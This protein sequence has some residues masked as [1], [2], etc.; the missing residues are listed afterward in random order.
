MAEEIKKYDMTLPATEIDAALLAAKNAVSY[1]PQTPTPEQQAQA[2]ANMGLREITL[3]TLLPV[4][5]STALSDEEN[6]MLNAAAAENRPLC[7]H[8]SVAAEEETISFSVFANKLYLPTVTIYSSRI[9]YTGNV[10]IFE[11]IS[12][13]GTT[14]SAAFQ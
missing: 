8:F 11:A 4:S 10:A 6:A 3:T 14:W 5:E 7:I 13:D 1:E 2:R 12:L 9:E